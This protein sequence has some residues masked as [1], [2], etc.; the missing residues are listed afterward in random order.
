M[1]EQAERLNTLIADLYGRGHL[2][3]REKDQPFEPWFSDIAKQDILDWAL[4]DKEFIKPFINEQG[5]PNTLRAIEAALLL[6]TDEDQGCD[7]YRRIAAEH[8]RD[9]PKDTAGL[10][11][12]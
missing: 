7:E 4:E 8:D 9:L 10:E 12:R 11:R 3:A 1:S 6:V 2:Q 5:L